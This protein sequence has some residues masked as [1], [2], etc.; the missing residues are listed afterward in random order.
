MVFVPV[1]LTSHRGWPGPS[2][3]PQTAA[4]AYRESPHCACADQPLG[5]AE[6][7]QAAAGERVLGVT[8][9]LVKLGLGVLTH[10][11]ERAMMI[12]QRSFSVLVH[13]DVTVY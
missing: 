9:L 8:R 3:R 10:H 6:V 2:E 11:S 4:E 13:N 7:T 12:S 5:P 1:G